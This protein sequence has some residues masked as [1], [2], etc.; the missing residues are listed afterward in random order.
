M[1]NGDAAAAKGMD[2][3]AGTDDRRM[4]YDEDNK[5]RDYIAAEIDNRVAAD[6]LKLDASKIKIQNTDPGGAD[7]T[8]WI[9]WVP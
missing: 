5:T 1:A 8:V 4:G 3:V 7:G 2:T 9:N 6:A